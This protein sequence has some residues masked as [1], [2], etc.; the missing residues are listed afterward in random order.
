MK[1][2]EDKLFKVLKYL[3]LI[4]VEHKKDISILTVLGVLSGFFEAV[5]INAVIP[6]VSLALDRSML[7]ADRISL[8]IK[9]VFEL[10][11]LNFEPKTL[12]VFIV[13][14]FILKALVSMLCFYI[15]MKVTSNYLLSERNDLLKKTLKAQWPYLLSQKM[16]Y[17]EKTLIDD[18]AARPSL[19]SS[20]SA[21]VLLLTSLMMYVIVALNISVTITLVTLSFGAVLF[22]VFKPL[23]YQT[24]SLS[25]RTI[26]L[27][28]EVAHQ[29]NENILG[30]KTIKILGAEDII[31]GKNATHFKNL[32]ILSNKMSIL[33]NLY[34][35]ALEPI[36]LIFIS[37]VFAFS[38]Y[39]VP[40]FSLVA[41]V[42]IIYL[43]QKIFSYSQSIQETFRKMGENLPR[44][45]NIL[46]N[47]KNIANSKEELQA[48][49]DFK[50]QESLEFKRV[51]FAY[52]S[53]K[54]ILLDVSF[55]LKK[56]E[57]LGLI[58]PSGAGKTTI[59]DL[60]LRL[61]EPQ[62][63]E[64][65]LDGKEFSNISLRK[66]RK[67]IGYVSQ[68]IFLMNDTIENNI[69]FYDSSIS[70]AE[71]EQ[72]TQMANI[73]DFIMELP[74]KFSAKVGERGIL[75]SVGQRQ[76]IALAR[77]FAR[78]PQVLVLDEATSSLDNESELAIQKSIEAVKGKITILVIAHRL[79]SVLA[80]NRLIVLE[81]GKIIEQGNPQELLR[82][83]KSYFYKVYNIRE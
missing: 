54:P 16:G 39:L 38:Y 44:L 31:A 46:E 7:G 37:F 42:A 6:L 67:N 73:Y 43:I 75:L 57:M 11:H 9:R 41:F 17:F 78:N 70:R 33:S 1:F 34:P 48:G 65:L 14:L 23:F 72:A 76:R 53:S 68:D 30:M 60:L 15:K 77:V 40:G 32:Q 2:K 28:K 49:S 71:M 26:A 62:A 21:G 59:V 13:S 50:L 5:G 63:G 64:I 55:R 74:E 79:S 35:T 19:L 51:D 47:E 52:K 82:D 83:N 25:A 24:R 18:I 58:G 81:K 10:L 36:T 80:C 8:A 45:Q 27:S 4:V 61:F 12:L 56:G 3:K 66:W 29:I 20:L 69:K 22:L